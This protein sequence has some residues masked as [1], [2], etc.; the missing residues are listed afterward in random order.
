[1]LS[2][3]P[4]PLS[5]FS[6]HFIFVLSFSGSL[7]LSGSVGNSHSSAQ[8]N[9]YSDSGYQDTSSGYLSSQNMGKAELRMQHSFPGACTGTLVRNVRAEGQASVQ[10]LPVASRTTYCRCQAQNV[11]AKSYL[12]NNTNIYTVYYFFFFFKYYSHFSQCSKLLVHNS[13]REALKLLLHV[14]L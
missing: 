1:M 7:S 10:V 9:S 8:M 14:F 13:T 12:L 11:S 5:S 6:L 4:V 2:L 3:S